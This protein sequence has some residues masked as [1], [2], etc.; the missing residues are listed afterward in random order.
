[1]QLSRPL[2]HLGH[3]V[4]PAEPPIDGPALAR[5]FVAIWFAQ[6]AVHVKNTR[7]AHDARG[8]DFEQDALAIG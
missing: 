3:P 7:R 6:L 1:M 8:S 2:E 4:E 5:D